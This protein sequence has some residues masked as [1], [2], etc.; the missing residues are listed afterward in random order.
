MFMMII[1]SKFSQLAT[2][3]PREWPQLGVRCSTPMPLRFPAMS[4]V[5]QF[6]AP[7]RLNCSL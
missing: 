1:T 2:Q 3:S 5:V 6:V 7:S 4:I